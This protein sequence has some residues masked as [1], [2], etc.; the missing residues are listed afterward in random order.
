MPKAALWRL[1]ALL[2]CASAAHAVEPS[3]PSSVDV[4]WK[5]TRAISAPGVT[6]VVVLDDE[7]AHAQLGNDSIE[8]VGLERGETV[9]LAYVSGTPV[10]IVVHVLERPGRVIPPSLLRR[11]AELGHGTFGAD[12]QVSNSGGST[13]YVA[14]DNLAWSQQIA[15]HRFSASSQFE[16]N[17]QFEGRRVNLR[18]GSIA[19]GTPQFALNLIDFNQSLT[20]ELGEDR[21][22]NFSAPSNVTLRGAGITL[23]REKN[24]YSL[25]G[26]STI[27]YYFLSLNATRDVAGFSFHRRQSDRV[28]LFGGASYVNIPLSLTNGIQRR[29]YFVQTAGVSYRPRRG[30]IVGTQGGF[31]NAGR[32]FRSDGSFASFRLS[33]YGSAVF[34]SQTFPLNQLQSLFAGTSAL[35][36]GLI[37]KSTPRLSEGIYYEH[38]NISPGLIYRFSGSS[39]YLSPN[40]GYS[41]A[42]GETLN[43]AYMYSRSS[44]GFSAGNNTGNRYDLSLSSQLTPSISNSAQA[45]V[46]S[47]QDPLQISSQDQFSVR[48][49][50]SFLFKG[51]TFLFGVEHDRVNPSLIAKLRQEISLL[52]PALQAEFL[53]NPTA[54]VDST[55]FPPEVKAILAAEQPMGTT[56]TASS[57][58][59]IGSKLRLS[60]NVSVTHAVNGTQEN[61]WTQAFGYSLTYQIRPTFQ[62]HS[63]LSNVFLFSGQ[64]NSTVRA[65]MLG[66]GFQKN[67]TAVP[68]QLPLLHR[69]RIIEGRVFRDSNI[70]GAY[71][72][73]EAGLPGVEVRLEDG[74]VATTDE[75]GRYRFTG[76]SAD[77]HQ[78]SLD[79]TQF[80]EP[81]RMT[82]PGEASAD[83]IQQH[84]VVENFGILDF[85]RVMG[86]IFNDLRFEKNRQ[87]D[88]KGMQGIGLLLEGG[89][90]PRTIQTI[91]SG[92]FEFDNVPPGD[93]KL[94]L[95]PASLPPNYVAPVDSISIHVSP[96]STVVENIPMR[97]LRSISGRVLLKVQDDL[98]TNSPKTLKQ[99][100]DASG[101]TQS[102]PEAEQPVMIPVAGA[103][104][105]AGPTTATTDKDGTFLLRNL[106]AGDLNVSIKPVRSV[107]D[108]INIPTGKVTLPAEPVQIQG[109]TIVVTN[110]ELVPYLT[111]DVLKAPTAGAQQAIMSAYT[112]AR[113]RETQQ[114]PVAVANAPAPQPKPTLPAK[115]EPA[116]QPNEPASTHVAAV[117][118]A[119]VQ[120]VNK[121]PTAPAAPVAPVEVHSEQK[122]I[123]YDSI[124]RAICESMP[125][126]GEAAQ[127]FNQ[128]KRATGTN[129]QK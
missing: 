71:N 128:L 77:E 23:Q 8:F 52:S 19:Y 41:I 97:A 116:L 1:V 79:L 121:Q 68:G 69:S 94:S 47:V 5:S 3:M 63:S 46:G 88:S 61:S 72:I 67:F 123:S 119:P 22:N 115:S 25:F 89:K 95:D 102:S 10:S 43:F 74:Q 106:P 93:Y 84:I 117:V 78:V 110:A 107:P 12:V 127:C 105:T 14:V 35:K 100:H 64:Q 4:Y 81:V 114:P 49:S 60:P 104:V 53:A 113:E 50:V 124:N 122:A 90:E 16:D 59:A 91:G 6:S 92:D 2:V 55:N 36:T 99:K 33:G 111:D 98:A 66:F 39:D 21:I 120:L 126:L 85:A 83:L 24:E 76:L 86:N 103:Q 125:S 87:P 11:E 96:V 31:S 129:P 57:V 20:G 118:P 58:L 73:G 27:P 29:N 9:V 51:Q 34:T 15:D 18:S 13:N 112:H 17:S 42:R 45:T 37:F 109:A 32:M 26:G 48:D 62:F 28:S 7:I 101:H 38:T 70:N 80:R 65:T 30:V 75:Q 56:L 54:F 40:L 44:G 108:G 82:T